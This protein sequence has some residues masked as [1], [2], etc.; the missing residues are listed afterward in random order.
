MEESLKRLGADWGLAVQE[1]W[2]ATLHHIEDIP[3]RKQTSIPDTF[4]QFRKVIP[5]PK[6]KSIFLDQIHKLTVLPVQEVESKSRVRKPV[7]LPAQLRPLPAG[8]EPGELP[9]LAQ[10]GV[11]TALPDTRTAFPFS[12]GE[13]KPFVQGERLSDQCNQ[14]YF[15]ITLCSRLD[16]PGWRTTPGAVTPSPATRRR[17]TGWWARSTRPSSVP[18]WLQAASPPDRSTVRYGGTRVS[19]DLTRAPTGSSSSCCGVTTSGQIYASIQV[20]KQKY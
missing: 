3:F 19:M 15:D 5:E 2:G 1:V 16:W 10:L 12:G 4:T 6:T 14:L 17:G 11:K 9:S 8:L 20:L 13:V 18:G 7:E